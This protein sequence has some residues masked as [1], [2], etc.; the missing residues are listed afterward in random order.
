M[1]LTAIIL[2]INEASYKK[3]QHVHIYP[4]SIRCPIYYQLISGERSSCVRL[5]MVKSIASISVIIATK[6][7]SLVVTAA[8]YNSVKYLHLSA[9]AI[10]GPQSRKPYPYSASASNEILADPA[11]QHILWAKH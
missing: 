4:L 9:S 3:Y 7:L 6:M 10:S 2:S 11:I 5:E 8:W 1:S